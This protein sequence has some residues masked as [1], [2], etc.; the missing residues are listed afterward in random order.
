MELNIKKIV[1]MT[2]L[3]GT[4]KISVYTHLPSP[5]PGNDN[6]RMDFEVQKGKGIQYAKIWLVYP[7]VLIEH[8]D[9]KT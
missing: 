2:N 1:I 8:I 7:G 3:P 9:T 6:L 4:D 5:F